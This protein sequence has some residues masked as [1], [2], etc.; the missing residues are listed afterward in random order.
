MTDY[1]KERRGSVEADKFQDNWELPSRELTREG[2]PYNPNSD[3]WELANVTS[4]MCIDYSKISDICSESFLKVVKYLNMV[5]LRRL[6]AA[7]I[8]EMFE[9]LCEII[10]ECPRY[11]G[12]VNSITLRPTLAIFNKK[13]TIRKYYIRSILS[14]WENLS[15]PF[16]EEGIV[17]ELYKINPGYDKTS[18]E[19][20]RTQ[21]PFWGPF[22][23]YEEKNILR[24]VTDS[25]SNGVISVTNYLLFLI[26]YCFAP[27]LSQV[28]SLKC[29]DFLETLND[30]GYVRYS[31]AIPSIKRRKEMR[32]EFKIR[33]VEE[34]IAILIKAQIKNVEKEGAICGIPVSEL[35]LFPKWNQERRQLPGFIHHPS[36]QY[37]RGLLDGIFDKITVIS[38]RTGGPIRVTSHRFRHTVA[39][40]AA[41]EG[42]NQYI[43]AELLDHTTSGTAI[44]Y[45]RWTRKSGERLNKAMALS[46]ATLAQAFAGT[47][48][49][50]DTDISDNKYRVK[51]DGKADLGKCGHHG[52]CNQCA[53]LA[54]YTCRFFNPFINAPHEHLLDDLLKERNEEI[55][56]LGDARVPTSLD[57]TIMAVAQVVVLARRARKEKDS[58]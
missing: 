53:P 7:Y 42:H 41:E 5:L 28:A 47:L 49:D 12:I 4:Q 43:I 17:S 35:P 8:H 56:E 57:D 11:D 34:S 40:R 30:E 15:L 37:L 33:K 55:D 26:Y 21:D 16:L 54:C 29:K 39:T 27:R 14:Y 13:K 20:V 36:D 1:L 2:Y 19:Y 25:F 46:M 52:F 9:D 44:I 22:S 32:T 18:L 45:T 23:V 31:L 58:K 38:E 24:E 50:D 10:F 48:I 51:R 6:T 3:K